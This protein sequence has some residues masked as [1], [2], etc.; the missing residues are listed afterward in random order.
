[1]EEEEII[2]AGIQH[3]LKR[4]E[5]LE[6]AKQTFLN[7]GYPQEL[8]E[9]AA[10]KVMSGIQPQIRPHAYAPTSAPAYR[11][12]PEVQP[13][14][15]P[16]QEQPTQRKE[17]PETRPMQMQPRIQQRQ[18]Q[19]PQQPTYPAYTRRR[20]S[21]ATTWIIAILIILLTLL[22]NGFLIWKYVLS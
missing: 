9:R 14:V 18:L 10:G 19:Q 7:A 6:K 12:Q 11:A 17:I 20:P 2:I 22:I 15:L 1:M 13:R 16:K 8:V 5:S 3:A 4:G 21:H